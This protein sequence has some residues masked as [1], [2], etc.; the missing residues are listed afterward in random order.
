[1]T[2]TKL[3]LDI[4]ILEGVLIHPGDYTDSYLSQISTKNISSVPF[5]ESNHRFNG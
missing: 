2:I 4:K 1:M 5:I 3:R